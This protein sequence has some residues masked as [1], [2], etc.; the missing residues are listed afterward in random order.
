MHL[1][2]MYGR[3]NKASV[4]WTDEYGRHC[5]IALTEAGEDEPDNCRIIKATRMRCASLIT[6]KISDELRIQLVQGDLDLPSVHGRLFA[7]FLDFHMSGCDPKKVNHSP[8]RMGLES[9]KEKM[10][11]N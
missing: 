4:K 1:A 9:R 5:N 6:K 3:E 7:T 2:D 11:R 10:H 8:K